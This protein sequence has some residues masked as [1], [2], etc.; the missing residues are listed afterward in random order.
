MLKPSLSGEA[1]PRPRRR[2]V[3]GDGA[4]VPCGTPAGAGG[5]GG[6]AAAAAAAALA[7]ERRWG[8]AEGVT[9]LAARRLGGAPA[10]TQSIWGRWER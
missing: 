10:L 4:G 1:G 8:I 6:D 9:A 3:D 2:D 5:D 7:R